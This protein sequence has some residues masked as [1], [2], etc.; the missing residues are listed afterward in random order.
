MIF[1][2]TYSDINQTTPSKKDLV[3]DHESVRQSIYTIL[4]TE[5]GERL[6][7]PEFY[8]GIESILFNQ[9]DSV[10]DFVILNRLANAVEKWDNRVQLDMNSSTITKHEDEN[11]YE[12]NLTYIV[13]G[14]NS[15]KHLLRGV[16]YAD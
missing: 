1:R 13:K 5:F 12:L 8:G 16:L 7:L 14:L 15:E 10:T 3:A 6:F 9:I 11:T 2:E 4:N